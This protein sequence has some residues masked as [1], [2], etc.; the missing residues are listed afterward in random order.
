MCW[1]GSGNLTFGGWGG[2]CEVLEHLHADFAADAITDTADFFERISGNTRIRHGAAEYCNATAAALRRA[3]QSRAG[4]GD[5]RLLHNFDR[6]IAEQVAA[7]AADLGGAERLVAAAPFWDGGPAV[8]RLCDSL[9]L[10]EIFLHSHS[11]GCVTGPTGNNW[12]GGAKTSVHPVRVGIMDH[13]TMKLRACSM[14]R[15]FEL[16][17]KRRAPSHLWQRQRHRRRTGCE[18]Q[19][20]SLRRPHS[21]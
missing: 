1:V 18:P 2:N 3:V 8:D 13:E 15:R 19:R 21:A 20:R 9:D 7:A 14:P 6:S 17:C 12:P 10:E 11:C 4:N 5:I 16:R